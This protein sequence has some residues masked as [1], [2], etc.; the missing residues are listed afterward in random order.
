MGTRGPG[1]RPLLKLKP[2][3]V[4]TDKGYEQVLDPTNTSKPAKSAKVAKR[5]GQL[6]PWLDAGLK[7]SERL[8]VFIETFKIT[9]GPDIGKQ[10]NGRGSASS[11][12]RCM[13]RRAAAGGRCA[14]RG[15]ADDRTVPEHDLALPPPAP[16]L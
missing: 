5:S 15:V 8:I 9:S 12:R 2:G 6:F 16:R 13:R 14:R 7:R 11:S 4:K 3:W 1:A 10:F